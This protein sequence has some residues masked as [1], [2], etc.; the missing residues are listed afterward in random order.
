MSDEPSGVE[1][2][3]ELEPPKM[4]LDTRLTAIVPA[5][6]YASPAATPAILVMRAVRESESPEPPEFPP[7]R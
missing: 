5:G 7:P 6:P 2:E 3:P 4:R 1:P